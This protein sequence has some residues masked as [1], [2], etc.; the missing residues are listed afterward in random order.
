MRRPL[1]TMGGLFVLGEAAC[2]MWME[3]SYLAYLMVI[4]AGLVMGFAPKLKK[5]K[6]A[7]GNNYAFENKK[8]VC[9]LLFLCFLSGIVWNAS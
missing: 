3:R 4:I 8:S 2:R 1:L 7:F 6:M 9:L 5:I